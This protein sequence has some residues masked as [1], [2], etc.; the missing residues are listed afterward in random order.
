MKHYPGPLLSCNP[1]HILASYHAE[2]LE[3]EVAHYC[4]VHPVRSARAADTTRPALSLRR[5]VGSFWS[6]VRHALV[7]ALGQIRVT[8]TQAAPENQ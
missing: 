3:R 4:L 6:A 8:A 2:E 5:L 7:A 1:A